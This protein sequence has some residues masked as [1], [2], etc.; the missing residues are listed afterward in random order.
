MNG[1]LNQPKV[2]SEKREKDIRSR[3]NLITETFK[4]A[5]TGCS[6][7]VL[8][9]R[10]RNRHKLG[11]DRVKG[12]Y[13]NGAKTKMNC[14]KIGFAERGK[15][16]VIFNDTSIVPSIFRLLDGATD[17]EAAVSLVANTASSDAGLK[18]TVDPL[19]PIDASDVLPRQIEPQVCSGCIYGFN[20]AANPYYIPCPILAMRGNKEEVRQLQALTQRY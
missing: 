8:N 12:M 14:V 19:A 4:A 9:E 15:T 17:N 16:P 2:I 3:Q 1:S 18:N 20:N 5:L 11:S 10:V 13:T 6:I 7:V